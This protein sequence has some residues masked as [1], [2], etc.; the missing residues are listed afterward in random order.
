MK[1]SKFAMTAVAAVSLATAAHAQSVAVGATVTGPDGSAVG[2]V[3]SVADGV[4]VLDT[5][6]HKAPLPA[7]A[8]GTGEQGPT[9]TVTKDQL[10]GMIDEQMAAAAAQRD[11]LLVAGAQVHTA[12]HQMLGTVESV[13]GDNV[14]IARDEGP[15]TLLR[16]HFA[17]MDN[18][19]MALFTD[20]QIDAAVA[21][22]AGQS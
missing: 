20:A 15:V 8:F 11:A 21:A 18:M 12:D 14:I 5:G 19:L 4:V 22:Q 6:K 2:T 7:D 1:F 13:D 16:E 3:E 17:A 9:I 10:D